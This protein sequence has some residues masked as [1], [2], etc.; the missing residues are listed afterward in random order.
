MQIIDLEPVVPTTGFYIL[1]R[2]KNRAGNWAV[3]SDIA[4]ITVR[5]V[6]EATNELIST[7]SP[8]V[9]D[10]VFNSLQVDGRW[11]KKD[12]LGF[13]VAYP[14]SAAETPEPNA[15]YLFKIKFTP[16]TGAPFFDYYRVRTLA[17]A[18]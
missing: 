6:D 10:V 4:S 8:A 9:A 11:G 17:P 3:Q 5:V 13:N 15:S 2:I 12:L 1:S 16:V 18:F 7:S 14:T